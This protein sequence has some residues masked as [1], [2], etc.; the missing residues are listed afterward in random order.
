MIKFN[1]KGFAISGMLYS[2]LILFLVLLLG[3][4]S[5]MASRKIVL[6]KEKKEVMDEL[7]GAGSDNP[8]F[9]IVGREMFVANTY[10]GTVNILEGVSAVG[11]DG[12]II[13]PMDIEYTSV[14]AF[15]P[16]VNGN[17]KITYKVVDNKGKQASD[18]RTIVV[19]NPSPDVFDFTNSMVEYPI[20]ETG[21]YSLEVW[22]AEGGKRDGTGVGGKGGYSYG[23][24]SLSKFDLLYVTVGGKGDAVGRGYNGGG[25]AGWNG[26]FN[27]VLYGFGG[28]GTDIRYYANS[29]IFNS[30]S[31]NSRIIVAGGG[32][33][34]G[35]KIRSGGAGGGANGM[36]AVGGYYDLTSPLSGM[37][38]TQT[39]GGSGGNNNSGIFGIGGMGIVRGGGYGGA[40]GGGW[41]GGGGTYPDSSGDDDRGGG[42]GS[43]YILTADS[44]ADPGK[45]EDYSPPSKYYLT[46]PVPKAGNELMPD[47]FG[48]G[49]ITGKTGHG[50][51]RIIPLK[52][53]RN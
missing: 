13:D 1:N 31:L 42:G 48:T 33:S 2:S 52:Y 9:T 5:I 20:L 29:E 40:G 30:E 46:N 14:P 35:A 27:P 37:G 41:F 43:G 10:G 21:V 7:N 51:A 19:E 24:A 50:Y 15:V 44:I 45:P 25:V 39:Q 26:Y 6:D 32:G 18:T 47:P 28:G 11:S 3:V 36:N 23:E 38:G 16:N 49:E 8:M 17:Y 34:V 22:G 53:F 12:Q 4:L